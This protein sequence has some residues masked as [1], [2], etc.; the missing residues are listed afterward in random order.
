M[1]AKQQHTFLQAAKV[2]SFISIFY[3]IN[4]NAAIITAGE[5][6]SVPSAT[7]ISNPELAGTILNDNNLDLILYRQ[8]AFL[9]S[10]HYN[11]RV[12]RSDAGGATIF[13]P[14][15][16]WLNNITG[17]DFFIDQILLDGYAGIQTDVFYRTDATGD[18]G[19]TSVSRSANGDRLLFDFGFPIF[20]GNLVQEAHQDSFPINI[21][22]NANSFELTGTAT[23][24][25]RSTEDITQ[26]FSITLLNVAVP[27]FADFPIGPNPPNGVSAPH[28][29]ILVLSCLFGIL[30]RPR[31]CA[32]VRSL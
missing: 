32:L 29:I 9:A 2:F 17:F 5:S 28:V 1:K 23:I 3:S 8:D 6:I 31:I 14:Q 26:T 20:S 16:N 4:I 7:A 27:T 15:L 12:V 22:T 18:R 13:A 19:P 10:Y 25:A 11:N 21:L 30:L 24:F